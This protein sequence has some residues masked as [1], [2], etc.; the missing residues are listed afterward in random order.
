MNDNIQIQDEARAQQTISSFDLQRLQGAMNMLRPSAPEPPDYSAEG[1]MDI[2]VG[3]SPYLQCHNIA[4][5]ATEILDTKLQ[6]VDRGDGGGGD[7]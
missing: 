4:P 6:P 5:P 2:T 7:G 3:D 1:L